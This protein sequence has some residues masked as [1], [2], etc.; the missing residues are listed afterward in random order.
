G[1]GGGVGGEA[2]ARGGRRRRL[3]VD[4]ACEGGSGRTARMAL[5]WR[6]AAEDGAR[7]GLEGSHGGW[8]VHWVRGR[9]RPAPARR[10]TTSGGGA[11]VANAK[12]LGPST[13]WAKL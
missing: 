6:A 8:H 13:T 1:Q 11:A 2:A 5:G 9:Q 4:V 3:E 12:L 7:V 10:P